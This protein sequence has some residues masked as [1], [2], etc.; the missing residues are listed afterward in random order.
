MGRAATPE[1]PEED[2]A[3]D[4]G[5]ANAHPNRPERRGRED[6]E[7]AGAEAV[8]EPARE[9]HAGDGLRDGCRPV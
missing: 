3:H 8:A 1:A 2:T 4:R 5:A 9:V 6:V 7:R